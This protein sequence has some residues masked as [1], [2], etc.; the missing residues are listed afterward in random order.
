MY[1]LM[2]TLLISKTSIPSSSAQ[3]YLSFVVIVKLC[4]CPMHSGGND[5]LFSCLVTFVNKI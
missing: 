3:L 4:I 2:I 5:K 1:E